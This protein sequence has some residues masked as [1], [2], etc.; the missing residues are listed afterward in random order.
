M[1]I[2]A[3]H[4]QYAQR[5]ES[6]LRNIPSNEPRTASDIGSQL[7]GMPKRQVADL[8]RHLFETGLPIGSDHRGFWWA[9][10]SDGLKKK[11]TRLVIQ[12]KTIQRHIRE[13]DRRIAA[14]Q[15]V[16]QRRFIGMQLEFGEI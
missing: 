9:G 1:K 2:S 10:D 3:K 13:L 15:T 6:I 8:A 4:L 14:Q 11:R 12:A 7:G 16:E 5:L